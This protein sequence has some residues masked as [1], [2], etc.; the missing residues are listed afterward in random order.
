M[1]AIRKTVNHFNYYNTFEEILDLIYEQG[2]P[3]YDKVT[4]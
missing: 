2:I 3:Q 1:L 4:N